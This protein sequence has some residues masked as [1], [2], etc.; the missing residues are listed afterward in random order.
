MPPDTPDYGQSDH[1][2]IIGY[3]GADGEWHFKDDADWSPPTYD[4]MEHSE[5][6]LIELDPT[7]DS[8]ENMPGMVA[9]YGLIW[10]DLPLDEIY[11]YYSSM[12][13]ELAG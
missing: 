11:D 2:R 10:E 7:D 1:A 9:W 5:R 12:Y 8:P 6:Y 3:E 4:D 13:E